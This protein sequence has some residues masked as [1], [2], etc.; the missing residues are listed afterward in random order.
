MRPLLLMTTLLA[1]TTS[2]CFIPGRVSHSRTVKETIDVDELR[3]IDLSTYNGSVTV[4]SHAASN[5]KME[6]KFTARGDSQ[7]EANKNCEAL[8]YEVNA[9][10]GKLG[11]KAIKPTDQM[12]ASA[13]FAL[14]VPAEC[15]LIIATSSFQS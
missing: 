3:E 5:V 7:E 4:H 11:I 12:S 13:A 8:T 1:T 15:A 2:G 14:S 6:V 10:D 9:G